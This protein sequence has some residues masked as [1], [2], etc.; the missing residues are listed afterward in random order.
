MKMIFRPPKISPPK[1]KI[2]I[3]N[4]FNSNHIWVDMVID[5]DWRRC[6][7]IHQKFCQSFYYFWSAVAELFSLWTSPKIYCELNLNFGA[8]VA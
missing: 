4:H 2:K 6:N 8:G 3:Y 5:V 7:I 1:K